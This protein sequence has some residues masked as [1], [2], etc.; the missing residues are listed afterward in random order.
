MKI[1]FLGTPKLAVPSLEYFIKKEDVEVLT[2]ITQPDKPAKRGQKLTPSPVKILA[3]TYNIKIYQPKRIRDDEN[4]INILRELRPDAFITVAFGQ[5]LSKE[6][7]DIPRL[8]V[9]NLHSSLLPKYRGPNPIQWAI[10][11][12]DKVTGIT[13]MLSEVEVDTGPTLLKKEILMPEN[14][15]AVELSNIIANTGPQMLY[16]SIAGLDNK[17]LTPLSQDEKQAS[18]APKLKKEDGKINW[19]ESSNVIHN[20]IRGM[21]PFPSSYTYFKE[22]MI[23]ISQ[24]ELKQTN[25]KK[26]INIDNLGKIVGII[27]NGIEVITGDGSIILKQVQPAGKNIM[28]AVSWYNGARIKKNDKFE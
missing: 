24:T 16:D 6:L 20:K 10:I 8:G 14:M 21:K 25:T 5:I 2:V 15:D 11:N 23:K 28:D 9:I 17:T 7:L 13:T 27:N 1:I 19:T 12:G 26:I 4:L 22:N 18:H 3:E